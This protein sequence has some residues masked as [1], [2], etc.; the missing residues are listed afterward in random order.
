MNR[1]I[2]NKVLKENYISPMNEFFRG[3]YKKIFGE[4]PPEDMSKVMDRLIQHG[5]QQTQE[6][7]KTRDYGG[8]NHE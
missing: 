2:F 8:N 5:E 6:I 4:D 1:D 7:L 3:Q